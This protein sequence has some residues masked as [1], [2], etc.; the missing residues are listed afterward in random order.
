MKPNPKSS[1]RT[2][3]DS[4]DDSD[5]DR[6]LG[7]RGV[8]GSSTADALLAFVNAEQV[9]AEQAVADG[10]VKYDERFGAVNNRSG[11]V[12]SYYP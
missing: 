2:G 9:R 4:I 5:S 3:A 10:Q 6:C 12:R 11:Q 8:L 1:L 7:V